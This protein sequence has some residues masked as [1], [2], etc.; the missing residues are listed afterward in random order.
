M[1]SLLL[2]EF[3]CLLSHQPCPVGQQRLL[4]LMAINMF[5]MEQQQQQQLQQQAALTQ[6]A[7][8]VD[9]SRP[10]TPSNQLRD[11]A[12]QLGFNMFALLVEVRSRSAPFFAFRNYVRVRLLS[13]RSHVRLSAH[14]RARSDIIYDFVF[15]FVNFSAHYAASLGRSFLASL[16][17]L[18]LFL[19]LGQV[20]GR[21]VRLCVSGRAGNGTAAT[22]SRNG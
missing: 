14:A 22:R 18:P 11:L 15:C 21:Q 13:F 4:Q 9:N 16:L 20:F 12:L 8:S 6:S 17:L 19:L 1:S 2:W 10:G 3:K 7:T 5:A